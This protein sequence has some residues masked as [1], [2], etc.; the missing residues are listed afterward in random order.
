MKQEIVLKE[1]ERIDDLMKSDLK[2]IQSTKGFRFSL[3]AVLLANFATVRSGDRV[4]DLGTGTGVIPLLLSQIS[5]AKTIYGV[6]I[7]PEVAEMAGRS[8]SLNG[9]TEQIRIVQGDLRQGDRL[10]DGLRFSVV[11]ANPPYTSAGGGI[12]NPEDSKAISRHEITCTLEDVVCAG[13][14]LVNS[15]GRFALVH[16]PSRLVDILLLMR[17][18]NLE[19]KRLRLV[20]PRPGKKA[21]LLLIEAIKDGKPEL[22]ILEPLYIYQN[23][24]GQDYTPEMEK[25]Y[26]CVGGGEQS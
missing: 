24:Q 21:N 19:P 25:I 17:Q 14:R 8:V 9:L 4:L 22:E 5:K 12:L 6:E 15:R 16:R 18:Y 3:D 23:G 10:F 26:S 2:I 20:H 7:Q 11:V 1:N 13:S